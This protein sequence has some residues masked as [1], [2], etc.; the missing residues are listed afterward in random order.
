MA[1]P[2]KI[3]FNTKTGIETKFIHT[4]NDTNGQLLEMEATYPGRSKEPPPHYHPFQEEH[5][6]ILS[7]EMTVRMDGE[8]R[9]LQQ[10]D[11]L[12]IPKNK[13]HSMWN[14]TKQKTVVNWQVRP[15][16]D[17]E[18]FFETATGLAND[19]KTNA[20]GRPGLLQS[21][22]LMNRFSRVFRLAKPAYAIQRLLF[23]VLGIAAW[24]K[25]YKGIYPAYLD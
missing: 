9:I 11:T 25:G 20:H 17:T 5:F 22:A 2:G 4:G 3:M 18:Y 1:Y 16:L 10:G 6:T 8:L 23:S 24:I 13:V 15:A 12:H 19:G 21:A 7:G 14:H